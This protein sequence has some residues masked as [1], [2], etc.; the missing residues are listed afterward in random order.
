MRILLAKFKLE[1]ANLRSVLISKFLMVVIILAGYVCVSAGEAQTNPFKGSKI[2]VLGYFDYSNG[3]EPLSG[4]DYQTFN[5]FSLKRGYF[6]FKKTDPAWIGM[7]VT[8]DIHQDDSGDYKVREK[9]LYAELRS[10]GLSLFTDW[11]AEIGLGH[12]PW[13]DFEEHINP[14][15]CQGTMA[16]ERAGVLNSAD[17]GVSLRGNFGG[18]LEDAAKKTGNNHYTGKYGSWHIGVYNGSGYHASENNENKVIEGRLTVRP[19]PDIIPGMQFSYFGL[20]GKGNTE[21]SPDYIVNLGMLSVEHPIYTITGQFIATTGNAKGTWIDSVGEELKT[22]GFSVFG[23]VNAFK[24][25]GLALFGRYDNFDID[26]DDLLAD[27]TAYS[28]IIGGVSYNLH[29]GNMIVFNIETTSYEKD[30]GGKGKLPVY[31][32]NLGDDIKVQL[33]YQIKY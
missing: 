19:L 2:E 23:Q 25:V 4:D 21:Q 17:L 6:T 29:K 22:Q 33:V 11:R 24:S 26:K 8:M 30:S 31:D 28:M 16:I 9:Y 7:R 1:D 18:K 32:N 12:I 3:R 15:R 20:Y 13:L 14:Y 5:S 10:E 27:E